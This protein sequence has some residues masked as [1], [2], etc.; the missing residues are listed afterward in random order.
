[1]DP[2]VWGP[3]GWIFLHCITLAYPDCPSKVDKEAM[4]NFF[5]SLGPVLPCEKCRNNFTKHLIK[6]PL[7][8]SILCSRDKLVRW[9]ID[10][11][12][13]INEINGKPKVTYDD[14]L[15]DY[16][17]MISK[18]RTTQ[19]HYFY[20]IVI[21]LLIVIILLISIALIWTRFVKK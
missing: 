15:F 6:Y 14:V 17:H 9:L 16:L 3:H 11:H 12:N 18:T 5:I 21:F 2:E 19:Q 20:A 10:I 1:M 13:E 7:T 8:D 4:K